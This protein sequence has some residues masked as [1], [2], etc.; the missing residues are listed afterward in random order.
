M[1]IFIILVIFV[2]ACLGL[3]LVPMFLIDKFKNKKLLE[4]QYSDQ[5]EWSAAVKE[6][7][8]ELK[9]KE[10]QSQY[11]IFLLVLVTSLPFYYLAYLYESRSL[12]CIVTIAVIIPIM[13][14]TLQKV[15]GIK[16]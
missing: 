1:D 10:R 6:L 4:K 14:G 2:F 8:K 9:D 12:A 15:F 16:K 5:N 7:P 11:K 13:P 3:I